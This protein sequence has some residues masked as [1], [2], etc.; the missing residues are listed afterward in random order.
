MSSSGMSASLK[1]RMQHGPKNK[2]KDKI[3]IVCLAGDTNATFIRNR[4]E[5]DTPVSTPVL[6]HRRCSCS[7]HLEQVRN[8]TKQ[9]PFLTATQANSKK[10]TLIIKQHCPQSRTS[11]LRLILERLPGNLPMLL[12]SKEYVLNYKRLQGHF[13]GKFGLSFAKKPPQCYRD[14]FGNNIFLSLLSTF[15]QSLTATVPRRCLHPALKEYGGSSVPAST[16]KSS[17][18]SFR[19]FEKQTWEDILCRVQGQQFF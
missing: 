13:C 15:Q 9:S 1:A 7:P 14:P 12:K 17:T 16:R 6:Q 19:Y 5:R 2:N 4:R 18:V 8:H 3:S 11:N 10:E